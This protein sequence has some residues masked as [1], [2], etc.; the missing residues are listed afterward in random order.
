MNGETISIDFDGVLHRY[1]K[2]FQDGVPYDPPIEGA[3]K[4]VE[5]MMEK[6]YHV[7]VCTARDPA[8]HQDVYDWLE[9]WGFPFLDVTNVKV[10]A[11]IYIDDRALRFT[12]WRDMMNYVP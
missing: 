11:Y 7:V 12:N 6:G 2:G 1:S 3:V 4:A 9:K 10:P 5:R 8:N